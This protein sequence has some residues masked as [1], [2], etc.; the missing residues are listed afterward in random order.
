MTL[1]QTAEHHAH[2]RAGMVLLDFCEVGLSYWRVLARCEVLARKPISTI[3]ETIMRAVALEVNEP[4]EL[5]IM[6]GLDEEV[7]ESAIV[8]LVAEGWMTGVTGS[9]LALTDTGAEVLAACS[10]IVSREQVIPFDYDGLLR[11][12]VLAD[13]LLEPRS[14]RERGLREVPAY[15][16]R[17]PDV[18]ELGGCRQEMLRLL[19]ALG[20]GRDQESELLAIRG[21]DRRDRLYRPALALLFAPVSAGGHCEIAFVVDDELSSAHEAAFANAGLLERLKVE[22]R[23]R[24]A[25]KAPPTLSVPREL[26]DAIDP[27]AEEQAR[28]RVRQA[29]AGAGESGDGEG[30]V[31]DARAALAALSPRTIAVY[32]HAPL[33]TV[34]VAGSK[35]RLLIVCAG[36]TDAHVDALFLR[37]LGQTLDS[38]TTARIVLTAVAHGHDAALERLRRFA[39]DH[40]SLTLPERA[41]SRPEPELLSADAQSV[42]GAYQ[43]LG[44]L[45]DPIRDLTDSRS[46]L[47]TDQQ[48]ADELWARFDT[49]P[50]SSAALG[51]RSERH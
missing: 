9:E 6:L 25:Q 28:E 12:P 20:D 49:Q 35:R 51:R 1:E 2:S 11:R 27:E 17:A 18:Q 48:T 3:D 7:L 46:V 24:A 38:G 31:R 4:P 23:L 41:T 29:V 44:H 10:E 22:R 47:R 45:G 43:W 5:Q 36:A 8:G 21:F 16:A 19:R 26:R 33:L 13:G 14:A 15:P 40:P 39:T 30:A 37:R 42:I 34:A 32:E 50:S